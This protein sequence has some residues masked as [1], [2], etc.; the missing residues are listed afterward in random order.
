MGLNSIEVKRQNKILV[1]RY[2]L[3]KGRAVKPAIAGDL[4]LSLPTV[5]QITGELVEQGLAYEAGP[6]DSYGGRRAMEIAVVPD[7][8]YAAG[9]DITKNHIDFALVNLRG[10]I[11]VNKR[12]KKGFEDS[13]AYWK[14]LKQMHET[15][16]KEQ[17]I[18]S[19]RIYG[20]GISLPGIIS[21]DQKSLEYSHIFQLKKPMDFAGCISGY[22]YEI[23]FF[24][25]AEAGCMAEC[26]THQAPD[27]FV[28]LSLSNTVGGAIV[29]DGQ[30]SKGKNNR[31]GELGHICIVPEGRLCYCGKKGHYD[32]Y[33]SA[34]LLSELAGGSMKD[35]FS[36]LK[37]GNEQYQERFEEYLR[38]LAL[39][40]YN[41][42]ISTDLPVVLGGYAGSYLNEYLPKIRALLKEKEI[43]D[44]EEC[45]ISTSRYNVEG[46]AVG[47]ARYFSEQFILRLS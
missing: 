33:G 16:L 38:A 3:E 4:K 39:M 18:E 17:E 30:I 9:I 15:F 27:E 24:N 44:D 34:L 41:L 42:H 5:R 20:L 40:I 14:E 7:Y 26:Y 37:Q 2:L 13:K 12:Y 45:Y 21:K 22:P 11:L 19:E 1:Y 36:G 29:H 8:R 31:S 10:E 43:F 25:D 6:Q 28:F 46:A 35:F 32:P 47:S 23:C